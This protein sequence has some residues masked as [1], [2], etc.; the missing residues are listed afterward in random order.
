MLALWMLY[1][2]IV[3][4]ALTTAAALLDAALTRLGWPRRTVW[5]ITLVGGIGFPLWA[6]R[7]A[8]RGGHVVPTELT[9]PVGRS[10]AALGP[11]RPMNAA[12]GRPAEP[13]VVAFTPRPAASIVSDRMSGVLTPGQRDAIRV[14][15]GGLTILDGPL[16]AL[17]IASSLVGAVVIARGAWALRR[18]RRTWRTHQLS[19]GPVWIAP[20]VGPAA[21]GVLRPSVVLPSWA[22]TLAPS[23][24]TLVVAHE[25]AHVRARDP[26]LLAIALGILLAAPWNAALWL[27]ARRL[28]L[29]IEADC[30]RRVL[31]AYPAGGPGYA[32]LLVD[33]A[34]RVLAEL[35]P[36]LVGAGPRWA[37]AVHTAL[38]DPPGMLEQRVVQLLA[39]LSQARMRRATWR[40][41][42]AV[43]GLGAAAGGLIALACAAPRPPATLPSARVLATVAE[44]DLPALGAMSD[45]R[46]SAQ[47]AATRV[48]RSPRDTNPGVPPV[49]GAEGGRAPRADSARARTRAQLEQL[50]TRAQ[51]MARAL[52]RDGGQ[53]ANA[54]SALRSLDGEMR[55]LADQRRAV[56]PAPA[57]SRAVPP[58]ASDS[59]GSMPDVSPDRMRGIVRTY[60]ARAGGDGARDA[61]PLFWVLLDP[62]G[63]VR[64]T[65]T[66][67]GVSRTS[68]VSIDAATLHR[69]F[70][71]LGG[72][73]LTRSGQT[74]WDTASD[75]GRVVW[76][77]APRTP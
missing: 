18:D 77:V 51:A 36:T 42:P 33:M 47:S 52:E 64:R 23:E 16:A 73:R 14:A 7:D 56:S 6:V 27:A 67:P 70:P 43:V 66:L 21:V 40:T 28:R 20:G 9:V 72:Q 39:A 41:A 1:A 25:R 22:L 38:F 45:G 46:R 35:P 19:D 59:D 29:A 68:H 10:P 60:M 24:L 48:V 69:A 75:T 54:D 55:A 32:R 5:V 65:T 4:A 31:R 11:G 58:A 61:A 34:E 50:A 37:A 30:D 49:V 63:A 76:A 71:E 3:S 15:S 26:L 74:I 57:A 8:R 44:A 53:Q 17:W 2:T 12:R 13:G 62:S